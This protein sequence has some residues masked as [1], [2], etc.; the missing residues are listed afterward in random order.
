MQDWIWDREAKVLRLTEPP[1]PGWS[2]T[3]QEVSSNC[4]RI[5]GKHTDGRSVGRVGGG[6]EK[7][8]LAE[9]IADARSLPE[10]RHA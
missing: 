9:C 2:F 6:D 5:N 10:K 3:M 4:W 7:A 8:L 1:L